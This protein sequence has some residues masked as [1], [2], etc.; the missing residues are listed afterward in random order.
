MVEGINL[1]LHILRN[2]TRKV[3]GSAIG[4][5]SIGKSTFSWGDEGKLCGGHS[6]FEVCL[7]I[8]EFVKM[9]VRGDTSFDWNIFFSVMWR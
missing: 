6:V 8:I 1:C 7:E 2:D 4:N 9:G 5:W 3:F